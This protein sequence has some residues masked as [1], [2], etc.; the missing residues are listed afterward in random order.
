MSIDRSL[1]IQSSLVRHRNVLTRAERLQ[2][3]MEKRDWDRSRSALALPKIA[4]R[5]VKAGHKKEK[6]TTAAT[7]GEEPK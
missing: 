2:L 4:H 3:L 5:K 6:A 7:E 1:R